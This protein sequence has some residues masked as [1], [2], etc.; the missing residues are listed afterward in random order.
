M[1]TINT[2]KKIDF[3][4]APP[5]NSSETIREWLFGTP[6]EMMQCLVWG[7]YPVFLGMGAFY[8]VYRPR[9]KQWALNCI[10]TPT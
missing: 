9:L 5:P 4:I 3:F 8:T 2:V 10:S 6:V 7:I 1:N